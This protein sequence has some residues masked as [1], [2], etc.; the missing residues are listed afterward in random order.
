ITGHLYSPG[1]G[2]TLLEAQT[3][4][5]ISLN[6][7]STTTSGGGNGVGTGEGYIDSSGNRINHI[8]ANPSEGKPS[9]SA[10]QQPGRSTPPTTA[11]S[12]LVQAGRL[13]PTGEYQGTSQDS[14]GSVEGGRGLRNV[15]MA[16]SD[17]GSSGG[18][19]GGGGMQALSGPE[20]GD[21]RG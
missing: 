8:T 17:V 12:Q 11:T 10:P 20:H 6:V 5:E 16:S 7:G 4:L 19:G 3:G 2:G 21:S 15:T 13:V 18:G 14:N 9:P 1:S